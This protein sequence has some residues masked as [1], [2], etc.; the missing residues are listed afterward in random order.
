[1]SARDINAKQQEIASL[2]SQIEQL[3]TTYARLL[4]FLSTRSPN[5]LTLIESAELPG[6]PYA[7]NV[8]LNTA[9]AA[10]I[11]LIL[12]LAGI[13]LLEYLDDTIKSPEEAT[14]IT[15]FQTLSI[16][17]KIDNKASERL[18]RDVPEKVELA[19]P[20]DG[21]D[22]KLVTYYAPRYAYAEAYRMLRTA[23]QFESIEKPVKS[24]LVTSGNLGEGK[25]LTSANLAIVTAQAGLRT[26]LIDADLRKPFQHHLF[27]A[28]NDTGLANCLL[29]GTIT[30]NSIRP[31]G[32]ENLYLMTSGT[33]PPNPS[34]LLGSKHMVALKAQLEAQADFII[35][36]VP[37]CLPVVDASILA[38]SVDGVIMIVDIGRTRRRDAVRAR[39]ILRRSGGR[40]LGIVLNRAEPHANYSYYEDYVTQAE[41]PLPPERQKQPSKM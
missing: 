25:S 30:S 34:E 19:N 15:G 23:I 28:K 11:G 27:D 38:R 16:L 37:P 20:E 32:V 26:I 41:K 40:I 5:T 7:P 24:I 14:E 12:S 17:A 3:Q 39:D 1:L 33:L 13:V 8:P 31:T 29:S 2:E 4:G 6:Y 21:L 18:K 36:D 9:L 22:K 35:F 10:S